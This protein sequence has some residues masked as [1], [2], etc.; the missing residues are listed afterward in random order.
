MLG[1]RLAPTYGDT[2][3]VV[4]A[5][6]R[7]GVPVAYAVA[8]ALHAPLD[9]VVVRKLGV[10]GYAEL[11][12]GAIAS[13]GARALNED[14]IA[15]LGL[16]DEDVERVESRE[17]VELQRREQAYRRGRSFP[18]LAGRTAL[19]VDD[20]LATGATMR[21][22]VAAV[23]QRGPAAV[24]VAVPVASREGVE[25]LRDEVDGLVNLATPAAFLGVG[26]WYA[27]FGQTADDEV[28]DLLDRAWRARAVTDADRRRP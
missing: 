13:G 20:G 2:Q 14:V 27:E 25:A 5:L 3:V 9:V 17:R 10:P 16:S 28:K 22:A 24:V 18:S 8:E 26:Q 21:A 4:L 15:S 19:L 1:A 11:A 7:G 23:R 6:P 12:M